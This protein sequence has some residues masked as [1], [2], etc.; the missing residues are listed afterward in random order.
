[1]TLMFARWAAAT[2]LCTNGGFETNTTGW[3]ATRSTVTRDTNDSK[4]GSAC[5]SVVSTDDFAYTRYTFS[6]LANGTYSLSLWEKGGG[7]PSDTAFINVGDGT[8]E[9]LQIGTF[10]GD[11][12]W[13]K[14]SGSFTVSG[15]PANIFV[16]LYSRFL[17]ANGE[18]LWDGVQVETGSIA[19]PYIET[20]G[21]TANRSAGPVILDS[22]NPIKHTKAQYT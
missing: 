6:G 13:T 3:A 22:A 12:D 11:A 18:M 14:K 15:S 10:A 19:T 1:M 4:F 5:M 20:D 17:G 21:G 16:D 8:T 7:T 9:L 2:N